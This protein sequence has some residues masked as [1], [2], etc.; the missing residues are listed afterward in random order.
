M[1]CV[2]FFS[3]LTVSYA[4]TGRLI[5]WMSN[6]QEKETIKKSLQ[7]G[8]VDIKMKPK[9]QNRYV[10]CSI[11]VSHS[12]CHCFLEQSQITNKI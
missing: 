3:F 4:D 10:Y 6:M 12:T 5:C 8:A 2:Y 11:S 1:Q 9:S 7:T